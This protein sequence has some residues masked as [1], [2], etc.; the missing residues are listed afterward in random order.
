MLMHAYMNAKQ[1]CVYMYMLIWE[2]DNYLD[3][4]F[5]INNTS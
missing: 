3:D 1:M 5:N 4:N 2:W